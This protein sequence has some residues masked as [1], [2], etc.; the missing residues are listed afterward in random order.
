M[1]AEVAV[2]T[3]LLFV[4]AGTALWPAGW[5]FLALFLGFQL[6]LVLTLAREDP[7]LLGEDMPFPLQ[8]G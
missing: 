6:A 3:T 1:I 5:A 2:L 7:S 8:E 4:P